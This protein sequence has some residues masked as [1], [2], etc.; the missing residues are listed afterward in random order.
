MKTLKNNDRRQ[1]TS[2]KNEA[3]LR[4]SPPQKKVPN[5]SKLNKTKYLSKSLELF[6]IQQRKEKLLDF[7]PL[8]YV[9]QRS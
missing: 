4:K 2:E 3:E 1:R 8:N 7:A 6:A 9:R 5:P